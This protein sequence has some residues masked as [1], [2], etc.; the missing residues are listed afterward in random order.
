MSKR[1]PKLDIALLVILCVV[2]IWGFINDKLTSDES[3]LDSRTKFYIGLTTPICTCISALIKA[4]HLRLSSDDKQD[5]LEAFTEQVKEASI[6]DEPSEPFNLSVS[7]EPIACIYDII[8]TRIRSNSLPLSPSIVNPS[9]VSK[10]RKSEGDE[11]DATRATCT[12]KRSPL[13]TDESRLIR[14]M[15]CQEPKDQLT[16]LDSCSCL[17]EPF[18]V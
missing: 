2:T 6:Q 12:F 10:R 17:L 13:V 16:V 14:L 15:D 18:E 7:E 5:I 1:I 11:C 9:P 3:F 8:P 4:I